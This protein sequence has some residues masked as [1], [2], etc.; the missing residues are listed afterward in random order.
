MVTGVL[1]PPERVLAGVGRTGPRHTVDAW[2][3]VAERQAQA[4]QGGRGVEAAVGR[5]CRERL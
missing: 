1:S 2:D 4:G 5:G 3:P